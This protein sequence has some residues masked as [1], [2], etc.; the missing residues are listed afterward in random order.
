MSLSRAFLASHLCAV[1]SSVSLRG[2]D[3]GR[4]ELKL[5]T[6]II[7]G[8]KAAEGRYPYAVSLRDDVGHF[9]GGSLVAPDVVLSAAHCAGGDYKAVVGRH[10]LESKD[11]DELDVAIERHHRQ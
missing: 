1:V 7:N 2:G 11:G 3:V 6:R 8:N 4:R 5:G 10:R 9:C